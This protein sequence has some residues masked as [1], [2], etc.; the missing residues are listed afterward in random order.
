MKKV[1]AMI[2]IGTLSAILSGCVE[3]DTDIE[4]DENIAPS[5]TEIETETETES[6]ETETETESETE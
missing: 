3:H 6:D 4:N 2:A 1:S 5:E